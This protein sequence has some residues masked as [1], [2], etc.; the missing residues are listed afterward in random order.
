VRGFGQRGHGS[1]L[2]GL[3]DLADQPRR[4]TGLGRG[5]VIWLIR[6]SVRDK[7]DLPP[8]GERRA[9]G[10][11][12]NRDDDRRTVRVTAPNAIGPFRMPATV[13]LPVTP[14]KQPG[15]GY[16]QWSGRTME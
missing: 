3:L 9:A 13:V 14:G 4:V 5:C 8:P 6:H 12:A 10:T 2:G 11:R 7:G 16:F 15:S 1:K